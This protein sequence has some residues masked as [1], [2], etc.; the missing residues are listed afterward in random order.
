MKR[1]ILGIRIFGSQV[2]LIAKSV[3]PE[4]RFSAST[5]SN[6]EHIEGSG[7]SVSICFP[8][9]RPPHH[10]FPV[11]SVRAEILQD[12]D[13]EDAVPTPQ[14]GLAWFGHTEADHASIATG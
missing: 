6:A 12:S 11:V 8:A 3:S 5:W 7:P 1:W 2:N 13:R 4:K 9:D 10:T 14:D